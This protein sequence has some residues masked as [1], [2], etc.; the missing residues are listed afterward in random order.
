VGEFNK[1]LVERLH[2]DAAETLANI[3]GGDWSDETQSSLRSSIEQFV[4]DFGFDLDEDGHPV[5]SDD[6]MR[7]DEGRRSS[8]EQ[9]SDREPAAV[10][11]GS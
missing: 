3:K 2:A 7:A 11:A 6:E 5:S 9:D 10:A 8:A 1:S 4:D